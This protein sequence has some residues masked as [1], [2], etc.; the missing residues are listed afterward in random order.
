MDTTTACAPWP[1]SPNMVFPRMETKNKAGQSTEFAT[2]TVVRPVRKTSR[3]ETPAPMKR[4]AKPATRK[5]RQPPQIFA[6]FGRNEAMVSH[7]AIGTELLAVLLQ[8]VDV[9]VFIPLSRKHGIRW[10]SAHSRFRLA[11]ATHSQG[12]FHGAGFARTRQSRFPHLCEQES[13]Q[14]RLVFV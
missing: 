5:P 1:R 3:F 10:A 9:R 12:L 11:L 6:H 14:R 4:T 7:V 2:L 8:Q 13:V